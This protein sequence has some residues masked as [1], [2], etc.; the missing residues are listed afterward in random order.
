MLV[1]AINTPLIYRWPGGEVHLEPG[2]PVELSEY[3]VKRLLAKAPGKVRVVPSDSAPSSAP[4]VTVEPAAG[5]RPI[6]WESA[7][8]VIR[9]GVAAMLAKTREG[10][11]TV[12]WVSIEDEQGWLTWVRDDRLRTRAQYKAQR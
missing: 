12:C 1:E 2:R 8:G 3:R 4:P 7:D 6:W 10:G 5:Q 11:K 9:R